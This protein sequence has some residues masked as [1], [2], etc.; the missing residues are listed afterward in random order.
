MRNE[1]RY[2]YW[3]FNFPFVI[4]ELFK[5]RRSSSLNNLHNFRYSWRYQLDEF[6]KNYW[7]VAV[8]LRGYG[9][10]DKPGKICDYT[11]DKMTDDIRELVKKLGREKFILIGHDWWVNWIEVLSIIW[12]FFKNW[13][14][15]ARKKVCHEKIP[16]NE[17]ADK[18]FECIKAV[19]NFSTNC[20]AII[21]KT[22][23]LKRQ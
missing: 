11:L 21:N 22:N 20:E 3:F 14:R 2:L 17:L 16:E 19:W 13:K 5:T 7:C 6:S 1:R 10:S 9:D 15:W 12:W 23:I 4:R 8:D 18:T